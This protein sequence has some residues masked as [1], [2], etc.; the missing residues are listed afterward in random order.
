MLK[1]H[2]N[3]YVFGVMEMIVMKRYVNG[4]FFGKVLVMLI[5]SHIKK[6]ELKIMSAN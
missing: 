4:C 5:I 1:I 6:L 3:T 2:K